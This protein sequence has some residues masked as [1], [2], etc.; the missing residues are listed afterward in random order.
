MFLVMLAIRLLPSTSTKT[1]VP[2][3][4]DK[5]AN[6]ALAWAVTVIPRVGITKPF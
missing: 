3:R 5:I 2:I 1:D 6:L 4:P